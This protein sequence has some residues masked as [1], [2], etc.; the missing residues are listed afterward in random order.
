MSCSHEIVKCKECK[1]IVS[2]CRCMTQDKPIRYVTCG[3]CTD[4][5]TPVNSDNSAVTWNEVFGNKPTIAELKAILENRDQNIVV[6]PDGS[7]GVC[8]EFES[9]LRSLLNKHSLEG[10]MGDTPDYV[11][12]RFMMNCLFSFKKAVDERTKHGHG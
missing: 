2:Q 11:L 6:Y 3:D 1:K 8:S 9:E 7:V 4:G 10:P 12:A 5:N